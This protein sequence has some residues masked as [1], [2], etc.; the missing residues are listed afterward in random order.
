MDLRWSTDRCDLLGPRNEDEERQLIDVVL[1]SAQI[2]M[3]R[4]T[5]DNC[6]EW[7]FRVRVMQR[8]RLGYGMQDM[9]AR[10]MSVRWAGLT[11][12]CKEMTREQFMARV[13]KMLERRV[14]KDMVDEKRR[15][16]TRKLA[17]NFVI[18]TNTEILGD[19]T[20]LAYAGRHID[21]GGVIDAAKNV[22]LKVDSAD[23]E[24][25]SSFSDW[26]GGIYD[27]FY[28]RCGLVAYPKDSGPEVAAVAE[29]IND[30]IR[31]EI[32]RQDME[33]QLDDCEHYAAGLACGEVELDEQLKRLLVELIPDVDSS[34]KD[35]IITALRLRAASGK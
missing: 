15:I 28:A 4:I 6:D 17:M 32:E 14:E 9:Q 18:C 11:V 25:A 13:M 2:G 30:A 12:D 10:V 31:Q 35:E 5:A 26:K 7:E 27:Q 16:N 21:V 33:E 34:D 20:Y 19:G 23:Y 3:T 8:A 22:V 1:A 29:Q 24:C